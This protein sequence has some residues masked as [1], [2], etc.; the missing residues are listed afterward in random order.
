[1]SSLSLRS[2]KIDFHVTTIPFI[3]LAFMAC[4]R[5]DPPPGSSVAGWMRI[6]PL[7]N[8]HTHQNPHAC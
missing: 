4:G 8:A 1:M 2:P 3:D 6:I 7:A 5:D